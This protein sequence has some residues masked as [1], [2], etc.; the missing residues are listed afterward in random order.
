MLETSQMEVRDN[1]AFELNL[2]PLT[3]PIFMQNM[4]NIKL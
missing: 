4:E 2:M 3:H 1:G